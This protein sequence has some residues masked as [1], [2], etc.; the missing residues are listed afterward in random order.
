MVLRV[1]QLHDARVP[2]IQI[3][4]AG[5]LGREAT[6]EL[7]ESGD[8]LNVVGHLEF[9]GVGGE[10]RRGAVRTDL[11]GDDEDVAVRGAGDGVAGVGRGWGKAALDAWIM[12]VRVRLGREREKLA[13]LQD[14]VE[15]VGDGGHAGQVGETRWTDKAAL[16]KGDR[17][18]SE[19]R[20]CST[21]ATSSLYGASSHS[22]K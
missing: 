18:Q 14:D 1:R 16:L 22:S 3:L 4:C 15:G 11:S 5:V 9:F 10:E 21:I 7:S 12:G 13:F 6:Q 2:T 20:R 17:S 8:L 19:S